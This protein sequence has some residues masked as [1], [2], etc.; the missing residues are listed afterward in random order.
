[1]Y[2]GIC[3]SIGFSHNFVRNIVKF[4]K[5]NKTKI[6]IRIMFSR[7]H[8]KP[9]ASVEV[10]LERDLEKIVSKSCCWGEKT[11]L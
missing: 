11:A 5:V 2:A 4:S 8:K 1:M 9:N 7:T 6:W 10:N 3:F